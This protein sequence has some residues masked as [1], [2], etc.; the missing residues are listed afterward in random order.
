VERPTNKQLRIVAL[1]AAIPMVGFGFMDNLVMITAGD[2]IDSHFGEALAISTM[3][4]A[5]FGQ[6]CSDIA[7]VTSGGIVDSI[8][9]KL[10]LPVHG[11]SQAQLDLRITRFYS[12]FGACAGVLTGCLL[13]MSILMFIDTERVDRAKK[14]KELE[15]I[16]DSVVKEG[17]KLVSAERSALFLLDEEKQ[18]LWSQVATGTEGIIKVPVSAGIVGA[19]VTSKQLI[20]I[21]DAYKDDRFFHNVDDKTGFHTRSVLVVPVFNEEGKV[22]GA[23]E[24]INKKNPDGSDGVFGENDEKLIQM[25]ASHVKSFI[26]IVNGG[27][28]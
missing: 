15:S 17:G 25:L 26:R 11:L 5:G 23:I 10:R 22:I 6:C 2:A 8:V 19:G 4:A 27:D 16:F 9:S 14:A 12:T 18:E 1:R 20:N 7:G 24:M 21:Q 3:T 13:G 28:D